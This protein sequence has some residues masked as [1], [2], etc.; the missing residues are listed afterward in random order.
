MR[1]FSKQLHGGH[2]INLGNVFEKKSKIG[3]WKSKPYEIY[4]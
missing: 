3:G 4:R 2:L 1:I